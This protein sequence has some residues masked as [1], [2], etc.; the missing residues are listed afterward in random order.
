MKPIVSSLGMIT[1]LVCGMS[2]SSSA[3]TSSSQDTS[4]GTN[5][6][7]VSLRVTEG[8]RFVDSLSLADFELFDSGVPQKIEG[9]QF[10]RNGEVVRAEGV[11]EPA[12]GRHFYLLFQMTESNSRIE[13][14]I[15]H[16][17]AS[18]LTPQD[19]LTIVTPMKPYTLTPQAYGKKPRAEIAKEMNK[20]L[21]KDIQT[22]A[23]EYRSV[24]NDL[25]RIVK[26]IGGGSRFDADMESDSSNADF[27]LE[28]LLPR[29]KSTLIKLEA[30]RLIDQKR[31]L[32]FAAS[33]KK[34]PGTNFVFLFY[35]R[36]FR[37]EIGS[38]TLTT[39][40]SMNQDRDD[41]LAGLQELFAFYKR[42][43]SFD[44]ARIRAA[45]ADSGAVF[46]FIFMD[47][48]AKYEFGINMAEQSQDAF[49]I[50]SDIVQA[51]GG[52]IDTSSNPGAGFKAVAQAAAQYYVLTYLPA[53]PAGDGRFREITVKTKTGFY[54]VGHRAGYLD[55]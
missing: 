46:N 34:S 11:S 5:F 22:S 27:S 8:K 20:L 21:R 19:I 29:Y 37:P 49:R 45:F 23:G 55:R 52:L 48:E 12:S 26:A 40:M 54:A 18:V 42:D 25:K 51:T 44:A 35:Q 47:R 16:L 9:L 14:A 24:L 38:A 53:P 1:L 28:F 31:F 6:I 41:I 15:D 17:F 13:E 43:F 39:L 7:K 50:F 3:F 33:I 36:E 2:A 4:S 32:D 30:M 10:V